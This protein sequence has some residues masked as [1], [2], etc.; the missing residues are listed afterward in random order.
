[1]NEILIMEAQ[2]HGDRQD[3]RII[4]WF[5]MVDLGVQFEFQRLIVVSV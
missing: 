4:S 2:L 5:N 1:V 3:I